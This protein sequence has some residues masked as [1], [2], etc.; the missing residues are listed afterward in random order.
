MEPSKYS[1][2]HN[3][4][5]FDVSSL[6]VLGPGDQW[7]EGK[8][9]VNNRKLEEFSSL[10]AST[11]EEY[12]SEKSLYPEKIFWDSWWYYWCRSEQVLDNVEEEESVTLAAINH[13]QGI[14]CT[15]NLE[16]LRDNHDNSEYDY[17]RLNVFKINAL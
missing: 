5:L 16:H 2:N 4:R 14:F 6:C 3:L 12:Q 17:E 10:F 9:Q 1:V 8:K 11:D 7:D 15:V 13:G